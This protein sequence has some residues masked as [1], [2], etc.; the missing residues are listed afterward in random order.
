MEVVMKRLLDQLIVII[1]YEGLLQSDIDEV[2]AKTKDYFRQEKFNISEGTHKNVDVLLDKPVQDDNTLKTNTEVIKKYLYIKDNFQMA[3]TKNAIEMTVD[4]GLEYKEFEYYKKY[5]T[6]IINAIN[7]RF[8]NILR[9][10]RIGVR[11]INSLFV[12]DINKI[13]E[14]FKN[15][16]F[17]CSKV[18]ELLAK[19]TETMFTSRMFYSKGDI[20]HKINLNTEVIIGEAREKIKDSE[21]RY[22]IINVYRII[23]DSDA[24]WDLELEPFDDVSDKLTRLSNYSTDMYRRCLNEEFYKKLSDNSELDDNIFG[25]VKN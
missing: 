11:K 2:V 25:G 14:Y 16:I 13:G 20:Y 9:Y 6:Y 19:E 3:F 23:L 22:N 17:N 8:S 15:D 12:R 5:A 24:F 18:N 7:E 21:E 10:V 4:A 1:R